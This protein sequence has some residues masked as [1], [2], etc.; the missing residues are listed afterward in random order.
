MKINESPQDTIRR[1]TLERDQARAQ[2]EALLD[3]W[4]I[5][6]LSRPTLVGAVDTYRSDT[7]NGWHLLTSDQ[8]KVMAEAASIVLA[9]TEVENG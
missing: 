3:S 6:G 8:I 1:L 4:R 2:T 7:R 9:A 5:V